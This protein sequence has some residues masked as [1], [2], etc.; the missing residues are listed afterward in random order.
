MRWR[1]PGAV[2]RGRAARLISARAARARRARPVNR[3][4]TVPASRPA[5]PEHRSTAPWAAARPPGRRGHG[6]RRHQRLLARR[7]ELL[8]DVDD[9]R[10]ELRIGA[11]DRQHVRGRELILCDDNPELSVEVV[12]SLRREPVEIDLLPGERSGV[13]P[14]VDAREAC[15]IDAEPFRQRRDPFVERLEIRGQPRA[16]R[17]RLGPTRRQLRQAPELGLARGCVVQPAQA[18]HRRA[19]RRRRTAPELPTIV[20]AVAAFESAS[21]TRPA[22]GGTVSIA[23][24][25]N[26]RSVRIVASASESGSGARPEQA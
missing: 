16:V 17:P 8:P 18:N 15:P 3:R 21:P 22:A 6:S 13:L 19:R 23:T 4:R 2:E 26:L 20:A 14:R 10:L 24:Q 25:A 9:D 11:R 1:P 7:L 5:P 12:T